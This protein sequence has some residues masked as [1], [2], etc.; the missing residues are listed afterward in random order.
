MIFIVGY[1]P[2][3]L[4]Y[5]N[6]TLTAN[7]Y[8]ATLTSG[9]FY[10]TVIWNCT[11]LISDFYYTTFISDCCYTTVIWNCFCKT[12][13]GDCCYTTMPGGCWYTTLTG[14]CCLQHWSIRLVLL[15]NTN[16]LLLIYNINRLLLLYNLVHNIDLIGGYCFTTSNRWLLLFVMTE[17]CFVTALMHDIV[18]HHVFLQQ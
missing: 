17:Y 6:P 16:R 3:I 7:F 11:T 9:W 4:N 8:C 15:Y 1:S 10:T 2:S 14:N 13:T 18:L 12:L 5:G